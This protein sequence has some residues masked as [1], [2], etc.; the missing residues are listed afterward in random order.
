[1]GAFDGKGV[2]AQWHRHITGSLEE[3]PKIAKIPEPTFTFAHIICPHPPYVFKRDG[4]L[5]TSAKMA[6]LGG[7]DNF[8]YWHLSDQF[9]D[10]LI[11]FN[12]LVEEMIEKL[13]ETSSEPPIII[14][15]G[16]HGT[17][18]LG[19]EGGGAKLSPS[20]PHSNERMSILFACYA[21][22][23]VT[24][25]LYD[26]ISPVNISRVVLNECFGAEYELLPDRN[27][28]CHGRPMIDVTDRVKK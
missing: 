24:D 28:W 4:S 26:S 19:E 7:F 12:K 5:N 23:K 20:M 14:V 27:Y 11:H 13:L 22:K 8:N 3:I 21:P 6:D 16:D 9:V 25:S 17:S 10:Q 18:Y 1:M 15:Q 2:M